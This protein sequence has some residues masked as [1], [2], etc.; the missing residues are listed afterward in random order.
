MMD[1]P[2]FQLNY[3]EEEIEAITET[4]RGKWIS[5]GPKCIELEN[6][7]QEMLQTSKQLLMLQTLAI[8]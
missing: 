1:I 4:I 3:G 8:F 2:L 6:L 7:M 5:T